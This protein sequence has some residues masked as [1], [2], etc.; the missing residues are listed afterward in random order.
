MIKNPIGTIVLAHKDP[1]HFPHTG[2]ALAVRLL[3][4]RVNWLAVVDAIIPWDPARPRITPS[5]LLLMLV[6]NVLSHRNPLYMVVADPKTPHSVAE[7]L[8]Q[9]SDLLSE[10]METARGSWRMG[11]S[12]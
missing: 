8:G 2:A 7:S 11:G 3:A 5:V 6:I 1:H 4:D 9:G 12:R 10:S